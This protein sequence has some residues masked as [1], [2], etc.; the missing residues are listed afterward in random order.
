MIALYRR[1]IAWREWRRGDREEHLVATKTYA[2]TWTR[3][4]VLTGEETEHYVSFYIDGNGVRYS[5]TSSGPQSGAEHA[6]KA[7]SALRRDTFAW[8]SHGDLPEHI[9]RVD[10]RPRGKLIVL[11]GGGDAA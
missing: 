4:G 7:H 5:R 9:R 1:F 11:P 3:D 6:G 8:K 2:T 10:G